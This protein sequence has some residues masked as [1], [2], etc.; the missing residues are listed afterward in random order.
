MALGDADSAVSGAAAVEA[1]V[2]AFNICR[3]CSAACAMRA[4]IPNRHPAQITPTPS[5]ALA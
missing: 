5:V 2:I 1:G 4:R 3:W